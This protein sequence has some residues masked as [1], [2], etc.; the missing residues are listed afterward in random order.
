MSAKQTDP[1][2]MWTSL[3]APF[4]YHK[5]VAVGEHHSTTLG[6]GKVINLLGKA[7]VKSTA[8]LLAKKG[9]EKAA[10]STL[11]K[12][13]KLAAKYGIN[14]ASEGLQESAQE[15]VGI[16]TE[17][18]ALSKDGLVRSAT[19]AED[20]QR[21]LES[22]IG[23]ARLAALLAAPTLITNTAITSTVGKNKPPQSVANDTA[24]PTTTAAEPMY[25]GQETVVQSTKNK[26]VANLGLFDANVLS[27]FN[28]ARKNVIEYAKTHFPDRVTN[29]ATQMVIDISRNGLDKLLSGNLTPTKYASAFHVP[30]LIENAE[31]VA[32]EP[33]TKGK[34]NING[35]TYYD[36]PISIGGEDYVAHIRVRDTS[37]GRKYYGHTIS[38]EMAGIIDGIKIEPSARSYTEKSV[39]HPVKSLGSNLNIPQL[40]HD[41]NGDI[42]DA[43][44]NIYHAPKWDEQRRIDENNNI[45]Y[46][47]QR[48]GVQDH[49]K[50]NKVMDLS[51]RLGVPVRFVDTLS[52]NINGKYENGVIYIS[53][54]SKTP[55]K[56]VFV[57]ELT[58]FIEASGKYND[59]ANA[60]MDSDV[61]YNTLN[62]KGLTL[63]EYRQ[64][65]KE[66]Y[67]ANGIELDKDGINREIVATFAENYLK[68]E[69][70]ISRLAETDTGL[71]T[72]IQNWVKDLLVR[73]RG[74]A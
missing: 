37:M 29:K 57:H 49:T 25:A 9:A 66:T 53:N 10:E 6:I 24:M 5:V 58:H 51:R 11:Q 50:I 63:D 64:S 70:M 47:A 59:L 26:V 4:I 41:V 21:I 34:Q 23:G 60:I 56:N 19:S 67:A 45:V 71:F 3:S 39:L 2:M 12:I 48:A 73:F 28:L 27:N 62:E 72:R 7:G 55:I 35:Y 20:R 69:K 54:K 13:G 46:S 43:S 1:P 32:S 18:R 33:Y 44:K 36:S 31:Y 38:G 30:E 61:F 8:K 42:V 65:I 40:A 22:G 14:V 15:V 52:D 74:T 68:D 16:E 17:K